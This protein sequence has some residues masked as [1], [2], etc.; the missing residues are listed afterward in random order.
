MMV[1]RPKPRSMAIYVW[2]TDHEAQIGSTEDLARALPLSYESCETLLQE[3]VPQRILGRATSFDWFVSLALQ[4]ASLALAAPRGL[5]WIAQHGG[6]GRSARRRH[7]DPG[8]L[9]SRCTRRSTGA[10][11]WLPCRARLSS[12]ES[13]RSRASRP[14]EVAVDLQA[15][16]VIPEAVAASWSVPGRRLGSRL[17]WSAGGKGEE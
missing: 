12:F 14:A 6:S 17:A 2:R 16:Q 5:D 7:V 13:F 11:R 8:V 9:A 4:P 1:V 15:P 10:E 3:A